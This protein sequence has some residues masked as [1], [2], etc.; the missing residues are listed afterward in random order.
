MVGPKGRFQ[1]LTWREASLIA[2]IAV[3]VVCTIALTANWPFN[4]R[5]QYFVAHDYV[6]N[7]LK[8]IAPNVSCSHSIGKSVPHVLCAGD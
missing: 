7:L 3:L 4:N 2:A 1:I 6:D 5:R 8:A